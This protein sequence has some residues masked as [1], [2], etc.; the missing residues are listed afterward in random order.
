MTDS[1]TDFV[2]PEVF[3]LRL[4]NAA[5]RDIAAVQRQIGPLRAPV[6][7]RA[8][9]VIR[10]LDSA[11]AQ[12]DMRILGNW[13][14]GYSGDSFWILRGAHGYPIALE[15][16]FDRVGTTCQLQ[17]NHCIPA[18]PLLGAMINLFALNRGVLPLHASAFVHEGHSALV[19]GWTKGGKTESLLGFGE[20]GAAYVGDEWIYIDPHANTMRGVPQPIHLWDWHFESSKQRERLP[21]SQRSKLFV[22]R[23]LQ[24]I[25][26]PFAGWHSPLSK[27]AHRLAENIKRRRHVRMS[28]SSLFHGRIEPVATCPPRVFFMASHASS[29]IEVRPMPIEEIVARM[30]VSLEEEFS[31]LT[32]CYRQFRFAF[33]DRRNPWIDQ[34]PVLLRAR[35]AETLAGKEGLAVWHPYPVSPHELFCAMRPF[36]ANDTHSS[37]APL[38]AS[39]VNSRWNSPPSIQLKAAM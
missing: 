13:E 24:R 26:Q 36:I 31:A 5:P 30:A 16:P 6:E 9:L 15:V 37:V 3:R 8:D 35:L 23:Q 17:C 39:R 19:T 22:L 2:L 34:L 20:Q 11:P 38:S 10:F 28:P 21:R 14:A 33:P 29:T 27:L 1:S 32:T 12:T 4:V 25:L 7:G 18:L